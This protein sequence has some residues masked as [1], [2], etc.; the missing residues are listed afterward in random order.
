MCEFAAVGNG[1]A[2]MQS[3]M[4]SE[5][6]LQELSIIASLPEN[7]QLSMLLR[8]EACSQHGRNNHKRPA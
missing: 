7:W 8:I 3:H 1:H 5:T 4:I 2:A 6:K